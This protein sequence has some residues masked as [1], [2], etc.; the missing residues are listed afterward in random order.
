MFTVVPVGMRHSICHSHET[1]S[2]CVPRL[3]PRLPV[4]TGDPP[5]PRL[6][7]FL[8]RLCLTQ[9]PC[10]FVHQWWVSTYTAVS[11]AWLGPPPWGRTGHSL[12]TI[13]YTNI[14]QHSGFCAGLDDNSA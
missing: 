12:H 9:I 14:H 4:Q 5:T 8:E 7:R 13:H 2:L 10:H 11:S 3:G 6:H 1:F